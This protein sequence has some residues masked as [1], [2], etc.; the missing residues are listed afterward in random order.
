M[1]DPADDICGTAE[2]PPRDVWCPA[3]NPY[4]REFLDLIAEILVTEYLQYASA[5]DQKGERS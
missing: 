3:D 1:G 2:K 4:L 5:N